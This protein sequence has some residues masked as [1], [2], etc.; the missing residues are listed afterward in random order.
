MFQ[1]DQNK[2]YRLEVVA[3][4]NDGDYVTRNSRAIGS[5][6]IEIVMPV[7]KALSG[8][9]APYN[10]YRIWGDNRSPSPEE[11]YSSLTSEQFEYF[12][13]YF[14]PFSEHGIHTIVRISVSEWQDEEVLF[15]R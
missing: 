5:V 9:T 4:Y 8:C 15:S 14:L 1:V 2:N 6:I 13:D 10:W 12:E 3:D 7:V 11:I